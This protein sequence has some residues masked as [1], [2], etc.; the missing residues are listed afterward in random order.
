LEGKMAKFSIT[1]GAKKKQKDTEKKIKGIQMIHDMVLGSSK[2]ES[3]SLFTAIFV[4][5]KL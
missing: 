3:V 2:R 1:R 5:L 4:M